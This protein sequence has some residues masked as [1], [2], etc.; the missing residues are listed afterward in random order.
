MSWT[1]TAKDRLKQTFLSMEDRNFRVYALGQIISIIGTWMQMIA[2]P[3]LVYKITGSPAALGMAT[4]ANTLPMLLFSYPGGIL[5]DRYNRRKILIACQA[6]AMI[7][8]GVLAAMVL[9]GYADLVSILVLA[10][11]GG[12]VTAVSFPAR[13]SFAPDL[14]APEKLTNALAL[15]SA[16]WNTCRMLGPAVAGV[17]IAFWGEGICFALNSIS[18]LAPLIT[19][20]MIRTRSEM[21]TDP[22]QQKERKKKADDGQ[23]LL[24]F[25][26]DPRI[27]AALGMMAIVTIFGTQY[28]V[29]MPVIVDKFLNGTSTTMG[30]MACA[31]GVGA[32]TGSLLVAGVDHKRLRFGIGYACLV[33]SLAI[34]IL[35]FSQWLVVSLVGAYLA[36]AA[37]AVQLNCGQ[38]AVQLAVSPG[39]RGRIM[40]AFSVSMLGVGPLA[41]LMAGGLASYFGPVI[42]LVISS[43]AVLTFTLV[44]F[45]LM[46]ARA[47]A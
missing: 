9:S 15:S 42:T 20:N 47:K 44:Y 39:A 46:K 27:A 31:G 12:T 21:E 11:I 33:L 14:V 1:K 24:T 10:F 32:L 4:F 13:Q 2:M 26:Q 18:F 41:G 19:L 25:L 17:V 36:G 37:A 5:A 35:A 28:N 34:M 3:W 43:L 22:D 6:L 23:N 45:Y 30:F 29:L 38:S 16:I 7:Q 8:S 40:G